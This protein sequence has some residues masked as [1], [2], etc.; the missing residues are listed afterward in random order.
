[1][2]PNTPKG[3]REAWKR[4][5]LEFHEIQPGSE[6]AR[7]LFPA[8]Y[9]GLTEEEIARA[10]GARDWITGMMAEK[11]QRGT[12]LLPDAVKQYARRLGSAGLDYRV[13]RKHRTDLAKQVSDEKK[14]TARNSFI[15]SGKMEWVL[16]R[17]RDHWACR[18]EELSK[19]GPYDA[20]NP[21]DKDGNPVDI[22]LHPNCGC[23][24]RPI[25]LSDD[26]VMKRYKEEIRKEWEAAGML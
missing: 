16:E 19:G 9:E 11:T 7:K 1:M 23:M 8:S 20:D 17:G 13:I 18:C 2:F 25:L 26:E 15:S 21:R 24:W 6:E 3:R 14:E 5:Y 12:P 10:R 4:Q 22:P